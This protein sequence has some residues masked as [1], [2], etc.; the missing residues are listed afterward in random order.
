M[1]SFVCVTRRSVI[2]VLSIFFVF[3]AASNASSSSEY[4]ELIAKVL[5]NPDLTSVK[6]VDIR[7]DVWI[8]SITD[9]TI[10]DEAL[11]DLNIS[12]EDVAIVSYEKRGSRVGKALSIKRFVLDGEVMEYDAKKNKILV[13]S[14]SLGM[15][16][17][18]LA[19]ETDGAYLVDRRMRFEIGAQPQHGFDS[20][21]AISCTDVAQTYGSLVHFDDDTITIECIDKQRITFML[22]QNTINFGNMTLGSTIQVYHNELDEPFALALSIWDIFG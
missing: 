18:A 20:I 16:T 4:G 13:S 14:P 15:I 1:R 7:N 6:V 19:F 22:D 8:F 17:M 10:I 11:H 21:Y 5:Y 2:T 12:P 3:F 9:D